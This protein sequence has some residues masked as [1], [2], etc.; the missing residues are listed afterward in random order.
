MS[1]ITLRN[2]DGLQKIFPYPSI[3]RGGDSNIRKC[4]WSARIVSDKCENKAGCLLIWAITHDLCI[5][6]MNGKAPSK[7]ESCAKGRRIPSPA[8]SL[9]LCPGSEGACAQSL[10]L[11]GK[12][13][14][15]TYE[16]AR[17]PSIEIQAWRCR[18]CDA[19]LRA[20][21]VGKKNPGVIEKS[22]KICSVGAFVFDKGLAGWTLKTHYCFQFFFNNGTRMVPKLHRNT[23][24]TSFFFFT[25]INYF[26]QVLLFRECK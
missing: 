26:Q 21:V 4:R 6:G 2:R 22:C 18:A 19:V 23:L 9:D 14:L 15:P 25:Y 17:I 10:G 3:R 24:T 5:A 11:W 8:Q 1:I 12:S 13:W 7:W 20:L 16:P